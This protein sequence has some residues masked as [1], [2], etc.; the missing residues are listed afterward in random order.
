M[1]PRFKSAL[2]RSPEPAG[3]SGKAIVIHVSKSQSL[4]R[5]TRISSVIVSSPIVSSII[6]RRANRGPSGG[7]QCSGMAA[8]DELGAAAGREN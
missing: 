5:V 8:K 7:G 3:D 6:F 4:I 1:S 2:A